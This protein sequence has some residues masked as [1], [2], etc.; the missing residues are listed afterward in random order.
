MR[1]INTAPEKHCDSCVVSSHPSKLALGVPLACLLASCAGPFVRLEDRAEACRIEV[2]EQFDRPVFQSNSMSGSGGTFVGA[3][4]GFVAGLQTGQGA[5]FLAPIAALIG[6][7]Y[8][9]ACAAAAANHP[10]A[11]AEFERLMR[12]AD[13]SSL[14]RALEA[15]LAAPRPECR[16]SSAVGEPDARIEIAKVEFGMSCPMGKEEFHVISEWRTVTKAGR[17]LNNSKTL[18]NHESTRSVDEWFAHPAEARGEIEA[19]M[20]QLGQ[21][22]AAQFGATNP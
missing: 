18:V 3:G 6:A 11:N 7:G 19:S 15:A 2:V 12:E 10:D 14:R 16:A 21:A 20:A 4:K 1:G 13:A 17:V 22:M 8:G 9:T 5:I